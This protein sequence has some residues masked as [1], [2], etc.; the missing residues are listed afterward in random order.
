MKKEKFL[1]ATYGLLIRKQLKQ[2][3]NWSRCKRF[4][5][6][7]WSYIGIEKNYFDI[8]GNFTSINMICYSDKAYVGFRGKS[9][10]KKIKTRSTALYTNAISESKLE[11]VKLS[12]ILW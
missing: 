3:P 8:F 10:Q 4:R 7:P 9:I 12:T 5:I 2:L 11:G 6:H 1:S